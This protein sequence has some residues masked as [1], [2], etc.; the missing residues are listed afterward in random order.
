MA[1]LALH[2][3][4]H[5]KKKKKREG[6]EDGSEKKNKKKKRKDKSM[7]KKKHQSGDD[8]TVKC[9]GLESEG[10]GDD[11]NLTD[12]P[13]SV[14]PPSVAPPSFAPPCSPRPSYVA[15]GTPLPEQQQEEERQQEEQKD[16]EQLPTQCDAPVQVATSPRSTAP[17]T[18]TASQ[19][20]ID[21]VT[22]KM[23]R[24][25]DRYRNN[26]L[27]LVSVF[28]FVRLDTV[29]CQSFVSFV[30]PTVHAFHDTLVEYFNNPQKYHPI[31]AAKLTQAV[32][33][34]RSLGPDELAA[35][36]GSVVVPED[37][38]GAWAHLLDNKP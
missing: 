17:T 20:V 30:V 26:T 1:D 36:V 5:K 21:D 29:W 7:K 6:D 16:Q 13:P 8:A 32:G 37:T 10:A 28:Q 18:G 33:Q 25:R 14:P 24:M 3:V 23:G 27:H 22:Q 15:S 4:C 2:E 34:R 19:L 11:P 9:L 12:E 38:P 35:Y 31:E